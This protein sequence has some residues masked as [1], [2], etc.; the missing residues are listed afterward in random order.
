MRLMAEGI[1]KM[2]EDTGGAP[3]YQDIEDMIMLASD[4]EEA[5]RQVIMS[6][7]MDGIYDYSTSDYNLK[8]P[9]TYYR[10]KYADNFDDVE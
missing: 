1:Q 7:Y 2:L 10:D 6:A 8:H 4:L 9:S 3:T 5:E